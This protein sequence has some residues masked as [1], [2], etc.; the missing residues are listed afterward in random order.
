MQLCNAFDLVRI[1]L[2]G[3]YDEG[4]KV[5]EIT[6][7]PSYLKMADFAAENKAVRVLLTKERKA[8]AEADFEGIDDELEA[9]QQEAVAFRDVM[10][11][12]DAAEGCDDGMDEQRVGAFAA[13]KRRRQQRKQHGKR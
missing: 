2:F 7:M 6:R 11:D 5:T 4:S 10:E 8:A 1:H 9:A 3:I 12:D 13:Q